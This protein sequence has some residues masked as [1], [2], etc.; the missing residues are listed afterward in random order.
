MLCN[1]AA[2]ESVQR[3]FTHKLPGLQFKSY[4]ERL[5]ILGIPSLE[6]RRLRSDLLFCYKM[7]KGLIAGKPE[8]YGLVLSK[9]ITREHDCKLSKEHVRVEVRKNYFGN[10]VIDPWNALSKTVVDSQSALTFKNNLIKFDLTKFLME[11][12]DAP[13]D[14][15]SA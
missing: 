1:I 12:F 9:S 2:L 8:N 14:Q 10:R 7:L 3:L 15:F 13:G 4:S 5:R 11:N 6:L